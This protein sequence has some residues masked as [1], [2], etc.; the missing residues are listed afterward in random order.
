M[1]GRLFAFYQ[2]PEQ[3]RSITFSRMVRTIEAMMLNM[4]PV[5]RT[6]I[7][8]RGSLHRVDQD[9]EPIRRAATVPMPVQHIGRSLIADAQVRVM[10]HAAR[11]P[12]P[13]R[14]TL[15]PCSGEFIMA[16]MYN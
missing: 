1:G 15:R 9:L 10:P 3:P 4:H 2:P 8:I 16:S 13:R 6:C 12:S 7:A 14:R 5:V 11:P